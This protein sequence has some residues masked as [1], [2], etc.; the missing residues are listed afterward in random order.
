M[1]P[2]G[3]SWLSIAKGQSPQQV[4]KFPKKRIYQTLTVIWDNFTIGPETFIQLE[5][6]KV[7]LHLQFPLEQ[8]CILFSNSPSACFICKPAP[9]PDSE[10]F[11]DRDELLSGLKTLQSSQNMKILV[12]RS[13][14]GHINTK[15]R[16]L[17]IINSP[18]RDKNLKYICTQKQS[19]QVHHEKTD[20]IRLRSS[21]VGNALAQDKV[22]GSV[23]STTENWAW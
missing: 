18:I 7:R 13:L 19:S 3:L 12:H 21:P 20:W 9:L 11:G 22:M 5:T 1:Q 23:P 14:G 4:L 2:R 8:L 6:K 15:Q 17:C 10:Y 16:L